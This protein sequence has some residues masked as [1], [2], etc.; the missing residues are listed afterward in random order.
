MENS[1]SEIQM[2]IYS[3]N[4]HPMEIYFH[5]KNILPTVK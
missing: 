1:G 2:Y 3:K 4:K 5:E